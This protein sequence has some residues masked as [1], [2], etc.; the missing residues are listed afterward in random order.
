MG[1]SPGGLVQRNAT[2][3]VTTGRTDFWWDQYAGNTGNC[4][5][6]NV[7]PGG[8]AA[9]V[10]S[11]PPAPVLPSAC[12][13]TSVGTGG[14]AQEAELLGC[15]ADIEFETSQCPWFTTPSKP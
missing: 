6:D 5:H 8:T 10:T 3:D 15:F 12:D 4:W 7:G 2:G 1:V 14:P 9:T 13:N 11:T